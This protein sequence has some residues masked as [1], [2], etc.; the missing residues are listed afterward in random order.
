MCNDSWR[1]IDMGTMLDILGSVIVGGL[2]I[3]GMSRFILERQA[4]VIQSTDETTAQMLNESVTS[5]LMS[6]LRKIGHNVTTTPVFLKC[7]AS[8]LTA[9]GDIDNNGT[10]DTIKYRFGTPVTSTPNPSD[11][12]LYRQIN[13]GPNTGMDLGLV[14]LRFVYADQNNATTTTPSMVRSVTVSVKTAGRI[15]TCDYAADGFS[16]FRISPRSINK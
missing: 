11:S 13:N 7:T 4:A 1:R 6:D 16:E 8:Q 5:T 15:S 12:L 14:G 10:V 2:I 3:L 9:L